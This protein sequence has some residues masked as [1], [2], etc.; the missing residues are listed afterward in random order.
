MTKKLPASRFPE[1]AD[2]YFCD[3]CGRDESRYLH[4][5]QAHVRQRR[6]TIGSPSYQVGEKINEIVGECNLVTQGSCVSSMYAI[7]IAGRKVVQY[8]PI[9]T[10]LGI[11][12]VSIIESIL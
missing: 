9:G 8:P 3:K 12:I 10:T 2:V 6:F 1:P 5:G 7:L 11:S 4:Q